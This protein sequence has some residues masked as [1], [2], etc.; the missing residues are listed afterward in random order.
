MQYK[1]LSVYK[2][3]DG[4]VYQFELSSDDDEELLDEDDYN[5]YYNDYYDEDESLEN[6]LAVPKKYY[7]ILE[8]NNAFFTESG[9]YF[10]K[11]TDAVK[12]LDEMNALELL[13]QLRK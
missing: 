7:K 5:N 6:N 8:K 2:R 10:K 11:L 9:I 13:K 1:I 3:I 12:A 4:E